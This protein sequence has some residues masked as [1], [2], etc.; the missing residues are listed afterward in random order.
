MTTHEATVGAVSYWIV[1]ADEYRADFYVREKKFSPLQESGV[2]TNE[3][4]REKAEDLLADKG[5]RSF[6]SHGQGRHT[7]DK[8][9]P[10]A[11]SY[12]AFAKKIADRLGKARQQGEFDRF[13]VVAAPRFLGVLRP[14]LA[15]AGLNAERT[16]DKELTGKGP[17]SV[18]ALVDSQ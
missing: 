4:A 12:V 11:Q 9:D 16:I 18:Q 5:G 6:D 13:I 10:R 7:M 15:A 2:L 14:A 17:A 1:V 3:I 8:A